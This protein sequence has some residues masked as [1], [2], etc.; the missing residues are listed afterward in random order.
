M[1]TQLTAGAGLIAL[2]ASLGGAASADDDAANVSPLTVMAEP[3]TA[4]SP[5]LPVKT[6]SVTRAQIETTINA[7]NTEDAL[8]YLPDVLVR[9]RHIGDTQAPIATRTSGVGSS[10]RSL[11]YADDV[12][13]S[14]LI[15]NNNSSA[16]P[17]WAFVAPQEIERI[18]VL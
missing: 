17:R 13:L 2:A 6:A 9:K 8:K 5:Q 12:L 11:I 1:K 15:G 4:Q 3:T 18:D 7:V 16:S 10:A 14:A